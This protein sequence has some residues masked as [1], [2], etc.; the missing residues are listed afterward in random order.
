LTVLARENGQRHPRLG[1]AIARKT[2]RRAVDRN[3]VKRLIRESFRLNA[4]RLPAVDIVVLA[5]PGLQRRS[6]REIVDSL[7]RHWVR[8]TAGFS[9]PTK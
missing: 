6:N 2:L 3:R 9:A 7:T 8:I 4:G 5:R 1:L